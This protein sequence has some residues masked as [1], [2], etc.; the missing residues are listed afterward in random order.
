MTG[1]AMIE[2][3]Q[4]KLAHSLF[5]YRCESYALISYP[6]LEFRMNTSSIAMTSDIIVYLNLAPLSTTKPVSSHLST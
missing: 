4:E 1:I 5:N 3:F 6:G 2:I